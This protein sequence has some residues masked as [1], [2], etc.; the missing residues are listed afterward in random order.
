MSDVL[1]DDKDMYVERFSCDCMDARHSLEV[2]L[3]YCDN[4]V[5]LAQL[6]FNMSGNGPFKWRL[7]EALKLILGR[8]AVWDE[9]IVRQEDASNLVCALTRMV[10]N[11]NT[12]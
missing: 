9:F 11:P 12:E 5:G 2:S 6:I 10:T 1:F 3:E 4:R 7:K 8:T